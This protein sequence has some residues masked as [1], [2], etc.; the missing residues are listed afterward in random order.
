MSKLLFGIVAISL[1][2]V[3]PVISS[4]CDPGDRKCVNGDL[5][6]CTWD[7]VHGTYRWMDTYRDC[8]GPDCQ[9]SYLGA[10]SEN[11]CSLEDTKS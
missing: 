3:A 8:A 6:E 2:L 11:A 7:A 10:T 1:F 4:A 9:Y 5:L